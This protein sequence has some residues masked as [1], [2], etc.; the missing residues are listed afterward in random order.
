MRNCMR[1]LAAL[2]AMACSSQAP[3]FNDRMAPPSLSVNASSNAVTDAGGASALQITV[4]VRNQTTSH[5]GAVISSSCPFA[6][7]FFPD[8][9][10]AYAYNGV[11]ACPAGGST[12]DLAPGDSVVL[13]RVFSADSLAS[14]ASGTYGIN[15]LVST[16][17]GF[18]GVWGGVIQ[19]PL[20]SSR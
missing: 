15:V 8:S 18:I 4:S 19:L 9:T 7:K 20:I 1:L 12:L 10:G 13:T 11:V 6:V 2:G 3:T 17:G 14:F 5:L 16:N